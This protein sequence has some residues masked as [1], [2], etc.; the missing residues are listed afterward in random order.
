M[1]KGV[2]STRKMNN[3]KNALRDINR[4]TLPLM[5]AIPSFTNVQGALTHREPAPHLSPCTRAASKPYSPHLSAI[6]RTFTLYCT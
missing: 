3:V 1:L 2:D 6:P 5:L 4:S